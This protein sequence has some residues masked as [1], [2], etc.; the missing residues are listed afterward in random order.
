MAKS[1]NEIEPDKAVC[2]LLPHG[3]KDAVIE[4]HGCVS[5]NGRIGNA[6]DQEQFAPVCALPFP[7][8]GHL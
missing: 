1:G 5:R 8:V 2:T 4:Q 7:G 6:M 3:G